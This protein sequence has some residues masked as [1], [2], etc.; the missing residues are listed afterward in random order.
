MQWLIFLGYLKMYQLKYPP[1]CKTTDQIIKFSHSHIKL[2]N[3]LCQT[4]KRRLRTLSGWGTVIN[5]VLMARSVEGEGV[6][7][8]ST[9][10]TINTGLNGLTKIISSSAINSTVYMRKV[11]GSTPMPE[12]LIDRDT[13]GRQSPPNSQ[14]RA[15]EIIISWL[16]VVF[17]L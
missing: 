5:V 10:N 9:K 4:R 13:T 7:N 2:W 1:N 3:P 12:T 8:C 17:Q 14:L 15:K 16:K 11:V 6:T